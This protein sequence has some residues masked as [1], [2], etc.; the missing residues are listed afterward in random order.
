MSH[1]GEEGAEEGDGAEVGDV[2]VHVVVLLLSEQRVVALDA[3]ALHVLVPARLDVRL[4]Q[5]RFTLARHVELQLLHLI[6]HKR[7]RG[8]FKDQSLWTV[9][10]VTVLEAKGNTL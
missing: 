6:L 9:K 7:R 1:Q 8:N 10:V 5:G 2:G 4:H 3:A